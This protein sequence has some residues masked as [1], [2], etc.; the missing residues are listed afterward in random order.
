LPIDSV[1]R[2]LAGSSVPAPIVRVVRHTPLALLLALAAACSEGSGEP[3]VVG[4]R[5]P[6]VDRP[7]FS[8]ERAFELLERQ[9]A[10]GPRVP[11]MEGHREQLE[12]MRA[13]LSERAD[14]VIAQPFTHATS[15]G[16]T[17][18]LTNLFARFRPELE[19]RV[20]LVAHWDT[21][22]TA[23][24]AA[25]PELRDEP[26]LGAND[27]ASG[28]A[29][30]LQL[31]EMFEQQPPPVGVDLLLVD[32]EDY[33]PD[34]ADMYLGARHFAANLPAGY[35][36]LYGVLLDMVG[37]RNPRF[38]MEGYS[39]EYA[40]EVL[41]RV[42]GVARDLGYADVFPSTAGGYI[43]DDHVPLNRAGIRT[44]DVIDFEYGPGNR[45]WHTHQDVPANTSGESLDI[46]GEVIAEL[47][48]RGG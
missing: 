42:W 5:A 26:I 12:W 30:L 15:R 45:Y 19:D 1:R 14:T 17:L 35:A 44:I 18:R 37:D 25:D 43:Q 23:D 31:A 24:Q 32:G 8:G 20:L 41:H 16:D 39:A 11:G 21:R 38:P 2:L 6:S 47:I 9:V 10:F 48:Y 22:P 29:V 13:W 33:G 34:S 3:A 40:P 46:V 7:A 28:T 4:G 27:G 36:P